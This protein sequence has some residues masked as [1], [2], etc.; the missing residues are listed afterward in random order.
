MRAT[1]VVSPGVG[2]ADFIAGLDQ[3]R[4]HHA[5]HAAGIGTWLADRP[6]R[7]AQGRVGRLVGDVA[8]VA[9]GVGLVRCL[10]AGSDFVAVD[11]IETSRR[12]TGTSFGASTPR[13]TLS[14]RISTTTIVMS[15]LMTILS[16]FLRDNTNMVRSFDRLPE[17]PKTMRPANSHRGV[18]IKTPPSMYDT[19]ESGEVKHILGLTRQFFPRFF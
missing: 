15:S 11:R 9:G 12:W 5:A 3:A 1:W 14:P 7:E 6:D 19:P 16:F 13:R 18:C 8:A 10:V 17:P 4:H 2:D